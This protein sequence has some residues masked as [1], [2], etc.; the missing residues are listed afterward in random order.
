[1]IIRTNGAAVEKRL[2]EQWSILGFRSDAT[3]KSV[4]L[5]RRS[6]LTHVNDQPDFDDGISLV[7]IYKFSKGH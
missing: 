4:L 1:M 6:E 5:Q 7:E 3:H 2:A